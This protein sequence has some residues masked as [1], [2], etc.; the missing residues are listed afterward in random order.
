MQSYNP[1]ITLFKFFK[2]LFFYRSLIWLLALRSMQSRYVGTFA[3]VFWAFVNPLMMTLVYWFVFSLGFKVKPQGDIPFVLTFFCS[4][5]PWAMF[6]EFLTVNTGAV[7]KN[8]F[9][10]KK[11]I[12][13]T[14]ILAVVDLIASWI[15]HGF[16]LMILLVLMYLNG[17][18]V[19]IYNFQFI[20]YLLALSVF[21]LGL[22][23]FFSAFNVFYRDVGHVLTVFLNLWFWL[24]PIVW[25]KEMIPDRY[26]F[27]IKLNP[28]FY[29][30]EGYKSAFIYHDTILQDYKLGLYF[31]F[32]GL[33]AL[34][35]GGLV[36]KKMK[37]EFAEAL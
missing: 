19:S 11:I 26:Q 30:V 34:G 2:A 35:V 18:Q 6:N 7:V 15:S 8:R 37:I 25:L 9:L 29:I 36:F 24:T 33:L 28:M 21:S 14:E 3:G 23:W 22:G 1:L 16:M 12:F 17:I 31:W 13:P 5:M 20:Y 32:L 4:L 10:V 27:F